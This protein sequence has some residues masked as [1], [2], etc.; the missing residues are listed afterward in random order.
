MI[1]RRNLILGL[2]AMTLLAACQSKSTKPSRVTVTLQGHAGMNPGPG[3]TDRPV[4]VLLARLKSSGSLN[5]ADYFALQAGPSGALGADLVGLDQV[6][7][8]PG[9]TV[10][11]TLVVEPEVTTLG[12]IALVRDPAGRTWRAT[13]NI[14]R[15][16]KVK[17]TVN[18]DRSGVSISG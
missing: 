18:L 12:V 16:S 6:S 7:V 1:E 4:T 11:R 13:R 3:G 9:A 2:G 15:G 5:S 10:S 17:M 14:S 8:G